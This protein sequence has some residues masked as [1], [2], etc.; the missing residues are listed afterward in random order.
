MLSRR[1]RLQTFWFCLFLEDLVVQLQVKKYKSSNN[2][3]AVTPVLEEVEL[4]CSAA[5]A[6]YGTVC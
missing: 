1:W 6:A 2:V 4:L 3:N 5:G